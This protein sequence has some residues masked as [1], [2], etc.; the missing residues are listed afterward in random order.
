MSEA[1]TLSAGNFKQEVLESDV[2]ALV[3]HW[4]A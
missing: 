3:D 2:P 1:I 4:A